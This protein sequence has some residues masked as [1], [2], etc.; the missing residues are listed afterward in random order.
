M[1]IFS[2][3]S[4]LKLEEQKNA[5]TKKPENSGMGVRDLGATENS[6]YIVIGVDADNYFRHTEMRLKAKHQAQELWDRI[7][8]GGRVV[9]VYGPYK[10]DNQLVSLTKYQVELLDR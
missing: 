3:C 2:E 1:R 10:C 8:P 7:F 6:I 4:P 5:V 9:K